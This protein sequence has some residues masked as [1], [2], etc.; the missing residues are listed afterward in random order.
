MAQSGQDRG[1]RVRPAGSDSS[2]HRE[3]G[4]FQVLRQRAPSVDDPL[5]IRIE[6]T[7]N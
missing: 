1:C 5:Q 2:E 6:L 4:A 7:M 3:H